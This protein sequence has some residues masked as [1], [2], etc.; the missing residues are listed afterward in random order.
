MKE[1][2]PEGNS[3][4]DVACPLARPAAEGNV[5]GHR[6]FEHLRPRPTTANPPEPDE[7]DPYRPKRAIGR[8]PPGPLGVPR[9]R[10]HAHRL[11]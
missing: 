7:H 1:T 4:C 10:G 6:E 9:G 2:S 3:P 11:V 8:R 5:A